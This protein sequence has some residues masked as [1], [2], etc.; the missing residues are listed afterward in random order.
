VHVPWRV[1]LVDKLRRW[2]DHSLC[3]EA[4]EGRHRDAWARRVHPHP[5]QLAFV[6][7]VAVDLQPPM[8]AC[9]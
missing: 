2:S 8:Q 9:S 6:P 5:V 3:R 4:V 1:S 7:P